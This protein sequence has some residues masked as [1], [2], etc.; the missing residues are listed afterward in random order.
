[1]PTLRQ[2]AVTRDERPIGELIR[3][4]AGPDGA[5][6]PDLAGKLP[7][8]GVWVTATHSA[9][10]QAVARNVFAKSLKRQTKVDK[11]LADLVTR[12]LAERTRQALAF[13]N[14]A[15][16]VIAG[17][18]KVDTAIET[19]EAV[20]LVQAADASDDGVEKLARKFRAVSAV[21]GR[22]AVQSRF[23]VSAE[24]SLAIG[25]PNVIHAALK[26]GGQT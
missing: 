1:M 6:V 7:G 17:F 3:F 10:G 22:P 5:I 14:K 12:L 8:R 9:V 18:A 25:R 21:A 23:L 2:C 13:A 11:G 24:L 19:G 16:L 20:A 15:G 4:V 26:S